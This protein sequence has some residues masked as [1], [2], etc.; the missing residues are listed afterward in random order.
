MAGKTGGARLVGIHDGRFWNRP[1]SRG[2]SLPLA[3]VLIFLLA[4]S[5]R[6]GYPLASIFFGSSRIPLAV[7]ERV[8]IGF[9]RGGGDRRGEERREEDMKLR[10]ESGYESVMSGSFIFLFPFLE[11][12]RG[13]GGEYHEGAWYVD[14]DMD[15]IG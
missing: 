14:M 12:S 3:Y 11:K 1:E 6:A 13:G 10:S 8:W 2:E 7:F 9:W 5:L 4:L 15:R